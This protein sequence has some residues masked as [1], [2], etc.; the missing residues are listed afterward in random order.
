[1]VFFIK[2][3][4]TASWIVINTKILF[5][6]VG[7]KDFMRW[8]F[9]KF[10]KKLGIISK[11]FI[12]EFLDYDNS[13]TIKQI[14]ETLDSLIIIQNLTWNKKFIPQMIFGESKSKESYFEPLLKREK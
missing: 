6:N 3:W 1:M 5:F 7:R 11:T 10:Q 8:S 4:N 2:S 12:L 9:V 13:L 14:S